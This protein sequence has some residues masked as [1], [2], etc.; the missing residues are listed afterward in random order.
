METQ[1][2]S[3]WRKLS[4]SQHLLINQHFDADKRKLYQVKKLADRAL[5]LDRAS[6][7][8]L[9]TLISFFKEPLKGR[10]LVWP[11]NDALCQATGYSER[12]IRNALRNLISAG[13][14]LSKNSPNGK[15]Y[16]ERDFRTQQIID[17]YGFDLSPL[18][19][20]QDE[21]QAIADRMRE[22]EIIWS[23]EFDAVTVSR[24]SVMEVIR[25]L[26]EHHPDIDT[27]ALEQRY[28]ALAEHTPRRS[29][30]RSPGPILNDWRALTKEA[31][32]LFN[33]ANAG[34]N[35]RHNKNNN[36]NFEQPCSKGTEGLGS[37]PIRLGDIMAACPDAIEYCGRVTDI[38]D[39]VKAAAEL[40]GVFGTHRSAWEE[41]CDELGR[42]RAAVVFFM[43]LQQ[44]TADQ[45]GRQTIKN[46]GGFYRA[47]ARKVACGEMDLEQEILAMKRRRHH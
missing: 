22:Q 18:L 44:Y 31:E 33:T 45:R 37:K 29:K 32:E 38:G 8:V 42:Q 39:L 11:S 47:T 30:K 43:V 15:R 9:G 17:A 5:Q 2:N 34:N 4:A 46:F 36:E 3:G 12:Q 35:C 28:Q 41:A 27:G 13:L 10:I 26:H 6:I 25:A 20:R 19:D 7:A 40:R 24:R 21:F 23:Q 14:V 16:A 1:H